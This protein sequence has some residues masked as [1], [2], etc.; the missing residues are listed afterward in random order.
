MAKIAAAHLEDLRALRARYLRE[1]P[2]KAQA[3]SEA[4]AA[5]RQGWDH[6]SLDALYHL[7]HRLA[8]SAAIYGFTDVSAA[9]SALEGFVAAALAGEGTDVA[10]RD[11]TL[12]SHV[13]ALERAAAGA[14]R[15]RTSRARGR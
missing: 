5:A 14:T 2:S 1:L 3:V 8:G 13:V 11:E 9:A 15:H 12:R 6:A 10:R 7:A 4:A